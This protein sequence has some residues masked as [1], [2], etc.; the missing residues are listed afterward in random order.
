ML[1]KDSFRNTVVEA[2]VVIAFVSILAKA[3]SF[4]SEVILAAR[5]GVNATSDA[6]YMVSGIQQ[7]VY[8]MLSVGIW[9]V[10]LPAYK[11]KIS[12]GFERDAYAL[13]NKMITF[14][15]VV[16]LI[17]IL[18]I[19]VNSDFI[20]AIVAPG[21]SADTKSLCA[22]L[23]SISAPMYFFIL[24]AAVYAAMLQCHGQFFASQIR[25]VVTHLPTIFVAFFL[26]DQ[27]GIYGLAVALI[28]GAA[29]R[30]V[31]E[32]PFVRWGYH[33]R[34][35]LKL[36][37]E[38]FVRLIKKLPSA[39]IS[40]SVTQLNALIDKVMG[41]TLVAG[42][43][44]ILNYGQRLTNFFSGL[45][46]S[47]VITATYP[48]IAEL[49][50]LDKKKELSGFI[51]YIFN[52]FMIV[53]IPISVGCIVYSD[54]IVSLV[55]ARGA[56]SEDA[57]RA[58]AEVFS[59]YCVGLFF[60]ASGSLLS[61]VFFGHGDTRLPMLISVA[62]LMLNVA[63]NL[64]FMPMFGG[65]GLALAT[66]LSSIFTFLFRFFFVGRYV[67]LDWLSSLKNFAKVIVFSCVSFVGAWLGISAIGA[68][69]IVL[70]GLSGSIAFFSYLFL[71][72]VFH[73]DGIEEIRRFLSLRKI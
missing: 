45:L 30:L 70:A 43:I 52:L 53:I 72:I 66:S 71:C 3:V 57:V 13:S 61:N 23:V 26:F 47:A 48:R 29:F 27:Y 65:K 19:V 17:I 34:F 24:I 7:V 14:M 11:D 37:T 42:S 31:I 28:I 56:F 67:N 6:Y 68:E 2:T 63:L 39:F 59:M 22:D 69:G 60:S 12:R 73:V 5:L 44:S 18:V 15:S 33:F 55:F 4:I 36:H 21:F 58:T 51:K 46:S 32:I 1:G 9:K 62:N 40:E 38:E 49:V 35:D 8:P 64:T 20:V 54:I 10:F 50:A 16:S 41:S 25:E